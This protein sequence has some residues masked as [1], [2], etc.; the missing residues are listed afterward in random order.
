VRDI[1][2]Y[3]PDAGIVLLDGPMLSAEYL[4]KCRQYLD[5]AKATLENDGM[6]GL[7]RF[8]LE[9][10]GDSPFG[11]NPHPVK[12]EALEDAESLS[13]WIRSEFGWD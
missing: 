2:S 5:V 3:H 8:S 1:R 7:Y 9:P 4:V 11:I 10:R 12:E 13:A 6:N